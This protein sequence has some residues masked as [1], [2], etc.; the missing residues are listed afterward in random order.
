[1]ALT[2]NDIVKGLKELG[3]P[4]GCVVMV[5]SALSAFGEVEGGAETV[6]EALLE[7][8]GPQGTLLMPA[9]AFDSPFRVES[10][11]SDVGLI[12]EVFRNYPGVT[13]SLHPTHSIAGMG[14]LVEELIAGHIDQ[15]S[16]LGPESPWGR[17]ARRNDAYI[18]F[19]GCDQDRN[20]LLHCAE[21]A[22][23]APYLNIISRK[24]IDADG[25]LQ[26]KILGKYPG[27]HRDFIGLDALFENA[28]IMK[29]AKIGNAVC[30]LT[31]AK[32]MLE[33]TIAALRRD[34]AAVLCD[35]RHCRDC[36][37]QRAAIKRDRL[38]REDF[39]LSAVI[40]D[41]GFAPEDA[42]QALWLIA[43]EGIEYIEIGPQWARLIAGDDRLADQLASAL[44]EAGILVSA[45]YAD[46]PAA[47]ESSVEDA[48]DEFERVLTDAADLSPDFIKLP[49]YEPWERG[50]IEGQYRQ[51]L[52]LLNAIVA[53]ASETE[54]RL[55]IE[56]A[57]GSFFEDT[58]RCDRALIQAA[59]SRQTLFFSLNP[60]HFAQVGEKPFLYT[61][62]QV[63][64]KRRMAQLMIS[65]GCEPPWPKYTLVGQG[66][67]EVKELMSILRCRSFSG[68]F[69]IAVGDIRSPQNFTRQAR[70]FWHLLDNM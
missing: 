23:D 33:L 40:D 59:S 29:I 56:N 19:L 38:S 65:D 53:R 32:Q 24:Y 5:H 36:V 4:E 57:P 12:T 20:T 47:S 22:L 55:L 58:R 63:K 62:R 31:A 50:D 3:L 30:R 8:I 9:M 14:P 2:K 43:A 11:P 68:H 1:M 66:Q 28:G 17:L 44:A 15:P 49:S 48:L 52:D 51:V 27:P 21:E 25:N 26:T 13:R 10:S 16:A 37:I 39:T 45:Y 46:L 61:F 41:V 60:A 70:A 6:I 7:A 34:P 42:D 54:T 35:N 64:A 67:G 69:T 18:L